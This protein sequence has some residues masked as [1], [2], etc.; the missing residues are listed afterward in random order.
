[1]SQWAAALL[2]GALVGAAAAAT[3]WVPWITWLRTALEEERTRRGSLASTYGRISEQWFPLTDAFPYDSRG[4]RF[5]GSPEEDRIIF[6]EFKANR[7]E[8]SEGQRRIRDLVRQGRVEWQEFR[9]VEGGPRPEAAR[10]QRRP[11]RRARWW[12]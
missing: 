9:F 3:L 4:F 6:Y 1:V 10:L 5:L 11:R 7:S 8:L 12:D 2:A